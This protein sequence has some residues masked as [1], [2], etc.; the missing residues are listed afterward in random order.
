MK[1]NYKNFTKKDIKKVFKNQNKKD[2]QSKKP[3]KKKVL[4]A[5]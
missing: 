2:D 3:K 1:T 5:R 4:K